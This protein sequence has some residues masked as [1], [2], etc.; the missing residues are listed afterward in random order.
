MPKVHALQRPSLTLPPRRTVSFCRSS[1][2][3]SIGY[4]LN[5]L[6]IPFK[7]YISEPL[8]WTL[9]PLGLN[10][11]WLAAKT[12]S[13]FASYANSSIAFFA[14][15]YNPET[16]LPDRVFT[17]DIASNTHV[18]R[19]TIALPPVGDSNCAN[20]MHRFPGA[21]FYSQG[22]AA[23]V[24]DFIARNATSR[25]LPPMYACQYD[26]L[27]AWVDIATSCTWAIPIADNGPIV[28]TY[29]VYHAVQLLET[30]FFSW[31]TFSVRLGLM[32]FIL[33]QLWHL[34]YRHYGPLLCNL[35]DFGLDNDGTIQIYIVQ[36]GD[37]TWLIL[38]HPF[39]SLIMLL[40]CF[41][42]VGYGGAAC[43][44]TSQLTDMGQFCLGCLYGSRTV[45]A[46]YFTM[47]YA[48]PLLKHMQWENKF[49]PVDPGVMALTASF[50]AGPLMYI[51]SRTSL[52]WLF[53]WMN[54]VAV[55]QAQRQ[56]RVE[57]SIL[58]F[59]LLLASVPLIN[60]FLAQ[61]V[62]RHR[63]KHKS[64]ATEKFVST[65]FNDWKH[66]YLYWFR[67]LHTCSIK[68]G[69]SLYH[70]VAENPRY[71]KFPLVSTRGSDC[72]VYGWDDNT[73]AYVHQV[74][75]SLMD[76]ALDRQTTCPA[77]AV[78]ICPTDHPTFAAGVMNAHVCGQSTVTP[79][80]K[81]I[82]IGANQC[83]WMQ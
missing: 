47:R 34:Y 69:G 64:N 61:F 33:Y 9:E 55:P 5:L 1:R 65:R 20:H 8:P 66:R 41:F 80:R 13:P 81:S 62:H 72:F 14:S 83:Q 51:T 6:L 42:N 43:C 26:T 63:T 28:S 31:L 58:A 25:L 71:K 40:D 36:L 3:Y 10:I 7:A 35:H 56:E 24:C 21:V 59:L 60:S 39:V 79:S 12:E 57:G 4:V 49:Q 73:D 74:R 70:L 77:L 44:R 78:S 32:G 48:T 54:Y 53:Q 82:H 30:P 16:I 17:R 15:K 68:E 2:L 76:A 46:S 37:P 29:Q 45:W 27:L 38:N 50:Y 52:V 11:T 75:L 18:L 67:R 22:K 19:F 23:F